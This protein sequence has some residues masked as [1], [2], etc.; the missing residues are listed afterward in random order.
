MKHQPLTPGEK[1]HMFKFKF[2]KTVPNKDRKELRSY[3]HKVSF[4]INE[5]YV[6]LSV[7]EYIYPKNKGSAG[8]AKK[9]YSY[10]LMSSVELLMLAIR[11]LFDRSSTRSARALVQVFVLK[12][13]RE[14]WIAKIDDTLKPYKKF[15]DK[16]VVHQDELAL[17]EVVDIPTSG[18]IRSDLDFITDVY[19]A[20]CQSY[21]TINRNGIVNCIGIDKTPMSEVSSLRLLLEG[22]G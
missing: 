22:K 12:G 5:A 18:Q 2:N 19:S 20:I 15:I 14:E 16:M 10:L 13:K 21:C 9:G 6:R 8:L 3:L 4:N 11:K 17:M 1:A 7:V